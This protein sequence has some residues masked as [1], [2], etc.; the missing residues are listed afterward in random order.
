MPRDSAITDIL[1]TPVD[2]SAGP[3]APRQASA[4]AAN[5]EDPV[6]DRSIGDIIAELRKLTAD[7]VERVLAH[8]RATGLRFGEAAV[9]LGLASK[10]DVLFALSQQFHFPYAP[11]DRRAINTELVAQNEPFSQRAEAFR[12]LRSQ[13]MMRLFANGEP[14]RALAVMSPKLGDGKTFIAANLA[15]AFA[16]WAAAPCWWMPTCAARASTRCSSWKPR[17]PEEHPLGPRRQHMIHQV[18]DLPSLYVLPVGAM[19]PNPLEL[20][21]RPAFGLLM[22][23]LLNKFDHVV[24]DTPAAI[25]GADAR[26]IAARCGA[27]L[28]IARKDESR[29]DALQDLVASIAGSPAKLAGVV[30][31]ELWSVTVFI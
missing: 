10:E 12:E 19:P 9:A 26:V 15:V 7:E 4:H 2:P 6:V 28:I 1:L 3:A 21:Q 27:A 29:M 8:Q 31:N 13:L 30:I 18:T 24:V 16:N 23:E 20:V 5:V 25:Y 14:R 22:Q 17:R 11:E